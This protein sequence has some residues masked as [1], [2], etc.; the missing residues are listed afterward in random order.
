MVRNREDLASLSNPNDSGS[1]VGS[2]NRVITL[3]SLVSEIE[4][5]VQALRALEEVLVDSGALTIQGQEEKE[6]GINIPGRGSPSS[7]LVLDS[8]QGAISFYWSLY[9]SSTSSVGLDQDDEELSLEGQSRLDILQ[10]AEDLSRCFLDAAEPV[11]EEVKQW[12]DEGMEIRFDEEEEEED[13]EKQEEGNDKIGKGEEGEEFE[14]LT[15]SKKRFLQ[16]C[17]ARRNLAIQPQDGRF[18]N[19]G[20]SVISSTERN[21]TLVEPSFIS[22]LARNVL[23]TGKCVGLLRALG[24]EAEILGGDQKKTRSGTLKDILN[25]TIITSSTRSINK[26]ST[27][28]FDPSSTP[29]NQQF[30]RGLLIGSR[31]S[32]PE[33]S[34]LESTQ[35]NEAVL[36]LTLKLNASNQNDVPSSSPPSLSSSSSSTS[37]PPPSP[38]LKVK[39]CQQQTTTTPTPTPLSQILSTSTFVSKLSSYLEPRLALVQKK[40]HDVL[41]SGW[42]DQ[43]CDL[44]AHLEAFL[45]LFLWRRGREMSQ[46]INVVFEQVD[47][48]RNSI[49]D[50]QHLNATFREEVVSSALHG[51]GVWID[52]SLVRYGAAKKMKTRRGVSDWFVGSGVRSLSALRIDYLVSSF[53]I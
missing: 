41:T 28:V 18:W 4:K 25:P 21:G 39:N 1:V 8:L 10:T 34:F 11:W 19:E 32:T 44:P 46:W 36:D 6:S 49:F 45:G 38:I 33:E 5:N 50:S 24:W 22:P 35:D 29:S 3:M 51:G 40:L 15:R 42:E 47:D 26:D 9:D 17:F 23:D 16:P 52:T 30:L 12:V 37:S 43:G 7:S 13:S 14:I 53:R 48:G 31:V 20:W 2:D 27:S